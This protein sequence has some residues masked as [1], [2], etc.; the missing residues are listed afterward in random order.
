MTF[1]PLVDFTD[2]SPNYNDR[3]Q[4]IIYNIPHCTAVMITAK[5]IG[6]IFEKPSRNASCNYGLG[7]DG[8]IVGIVP[9]NKR[10]W[11][12]SSQWVDQRG[13]TFEIASENTA[14][15]KMN[16]AAFENWKK[17]SVDIMIRYGKT[18]LIYIPDKD[19]A[20]AYKP[21]KN[22]MVIMLHRW[23]AAKACPGEW[24]IQRLPE[25][26]AEINARVAAALQAADVD[27]IAPVQ[28]ENA[29]EYTVKKRDR[30]SKIGAI[31]GYTADELAAYNGIENPNLIYP[32]QVIK[33]PPKEKKSLTPARAA[34]VLQKVYNKT[35]EGLTVDEI[36]EAFYM[37]I[38][39]LRE[40][41]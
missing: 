1:S 14:P 11:C 32:G 38:K 25:A 39:L 17:L 18:K 21:A 22:E 29:E 4:E 37:A 10:S 33:I 3:N 41:K 34:D 40:Q 30:L 24:L 12:T 26:V 20:K 8:K 31:Y 19:K 27:K 13:V 5:R 7:C 15:Y 28:P 6:E 16:E 2:L 36:E 23:F 9:E 35:P